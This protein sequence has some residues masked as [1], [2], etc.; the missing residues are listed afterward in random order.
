[1]SKH[2]LYQALW[3]CFTLFL[4]L[5][6]GEYLIPE[7]DAELMYDR[8]NG[9]IY[10]GRLTEWNGDPLYIKY[11]EKEG[12]S[13]HYTFI[14]TA[15][16]LMQIFNM[17]C[18]RKI[19]DEWNIFDGIFKNPMFVILWIVIMGGQILITQFGG[20]VFQTCFKGLDGPQWGIAFLAG[21]TTFVVNAILKCLPDWIAPC[22]GDDRVF[23]ARYPHRATKLH[24]DDGVVEEKK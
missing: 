21:M 14:F 22:M 17:V 4:F 13:R 11:A 10:P 18:C 12:P 20:L 23:N 3:Q 9:Y 7:S 15:F 16:V 6:A 1:M 2:I 24:D 8:P 5:F 19:H